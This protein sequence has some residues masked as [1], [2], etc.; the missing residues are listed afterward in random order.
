MGKVPSKTKKPA[1][2]AVHTCETCV[3]AVD[4]APGDKTHGD[5]PQVAHGLH[6]G[7][8]W[9]GFPE[10]GVTPKA[11][12]LRENPYVWMMTRGSFMETP[13]GKQQK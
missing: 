13:M 5:D 9:V 10:M 1:P 4:H 2:Q 12:W 6:M 8:T 3:L 7:C 11:G